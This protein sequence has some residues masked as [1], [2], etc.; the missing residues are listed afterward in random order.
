LG[1]AGRGESVTRG[2]MSLRFTSL[3]FIGGGD[4]GDFE[5]T[6]DRRGLVP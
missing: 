2:S 1:V 4:F 5:G 6:G 3:R